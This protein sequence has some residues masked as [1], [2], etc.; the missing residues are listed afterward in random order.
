MNNEFPPLAHLPSLADL[1][2]PPAYTSSIDVHVGVLYAHGH[3]VGALVVTV[4]T[5]G[6]DAS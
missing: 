6:V 4:A 2:P 3:G 1:C 5:A